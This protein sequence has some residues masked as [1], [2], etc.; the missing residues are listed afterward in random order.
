MTSEITS[1]NSACLFKVYFDLKRFILEKEIFKEGKDAWKY[2]VYLKRRCGDCFRNLSPE[3]KEKMLQSL[4]KEELFLFQEEFLTDD[5]LETDNR[6]INE[7]KQELTEL[8]KDRRSVGK[9]I[10]KLQKDLD[11]QEKVLMGKEKEREQEEKRYHLLK[12]STT[13]K[14]GNAVFK[15]CFPWLKML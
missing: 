2:M 1:Y 13:Y 14:V 10:E 15:H 4:T 11:Y 3:E 12:S 6:P 5:E 9:E 8:K 7:I